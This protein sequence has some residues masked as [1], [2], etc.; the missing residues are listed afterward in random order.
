VSTIVE[1]LEQKRAAARLG[2]GQARIDKQ[3]AKGKLTARERLEILLDEGSFEEYDAF[4]THRCTDFGMEEDKPA[5]D[6]VVTG[7]GTINGRMVYVFSQ[8]FTVF[9]G[10]LSER[11]CGCL[12]AQ[13]EGVWR[14]SANQRHH[15]PLRGRRGVLTSDDG[16]HLHGGGQ[17]IHVRNRPG[18]RED[19]YE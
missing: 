4:V 6:G 1:A 14:C 13:R 16:F 18:C 10:S 2:G 5:G 12:S 19:R 9:G 3:H 11:L 7:W 15:G 17:L 8:D